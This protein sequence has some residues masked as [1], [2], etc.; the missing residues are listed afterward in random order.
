MYDGAE[1]ALYKRVGIR[2]R[3]GVM[4]ADTLVPSSFSRDSLQLWFSPWSTL[5]PS[6]VEI[7]V[8]PVPHG[9]KIFLRRRSAALRRSAPSARRTALVSRPHNSHL[10]ART[11]RRTHP[12][13]AARTESG[14][15]PPR[16]ATEP[17]PRLTA[18]CDLSC[19]AGAHLDWDAVTL[20]SEEQAPPSSPSKPSRPCQTV[21]LS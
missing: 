15:A 17:L 9:P 1:N 10:R 6:S 11:A 19:H 4:H 20:S 21:G 2:A 14:R 18:T 12:E 3:V 7:L 8:L 16:G 5:V 13:R